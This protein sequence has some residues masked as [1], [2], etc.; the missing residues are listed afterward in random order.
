[1]RTTITVDDVIFGDL[2]NLTQAKSRNEAINTALA[3]WVRRQKIQRLKSLRGKLS[4]ADDL[5][6]RRQLE[7]GEA[8]SL[9][10]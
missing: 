9:G 1:M 5:D 6:D 3:E 7:I 4:I 8:R 10:R 2:M